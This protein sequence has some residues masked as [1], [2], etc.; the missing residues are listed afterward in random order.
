MPRHLLLPVAVLV[1]G[2]PGLASAQSQTSWSQ[3][4]GW[5]GHI[6]IGGTKAEA[7]SGMAFNG[8]LT[9]WARRLFVEV[10]GF[11]ATIVE[12]DSGRTY[13][14]DPGDDDHGST[15]TD[16][17]TGSDAGISSCVGVLD[18]SYAFS[19]G[20]GIQIPHTIVQIG[21]GERFTQGTRQWYGM[22]NVI[23][24]T[25]HLAEVNGN[26]RMYMKTYFGKSYVAVFWS[27]VFGRLAH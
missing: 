8:G 27:V 25:G 15:C 18:G 10:N 6:G 7:A 9:V 4:S 24:P 3:P 14:Y 5:Y 12:G 13:E 22:A 11:D 20:A 19:L 21:A 2:L 1:C 16:P 23:I 17:S 26:T